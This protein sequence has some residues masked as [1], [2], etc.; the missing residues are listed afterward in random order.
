MDALNQRKWDSAARAYDFMNGYGPE[1][2]WEPFKRRLFSLMWGK[3]LFVAIGTGQNIRF[4][5]PGRDVVGVDISAR[6]LDLARPRVK[7]YSGTIE[8]QHAD[9]HDLDD[10][11]ATYDQVF[12]SCT[13]CSVPNPVAGLSVLRRVLKP[14]G[15]LHMFEHT[16]SRYFPFNAMLNTLTPLVRRF[17]PELNR[18][19][20]ANVQRAGFEVRAVDPVYLDVVKMIHAVVPQGGASASP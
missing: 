18:D 4:F 10:P 2:R 7:A 14:G 12:T 11:D 15:Q 19:T 17:G 9:V 20:V 8:L 5:P 16:G 6:M 3:V 1:R 13:F